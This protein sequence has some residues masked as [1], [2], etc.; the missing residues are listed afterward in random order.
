MRRRRCPRCPRNLWNIPRLRILNSNL[1]FFGADG[2]C[3]SGYVFY[4]C[5]STGMMVWSVNT[6]ISRI[7]NN[8]EYGLNR[9]NSALSRNHSAREHQLTQV[10]QL[11]YGPWMKSSQ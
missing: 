7:C 3:D 5:S 4:S 11:R 10:R 1:W 8:L 9:V 2:C 6:G